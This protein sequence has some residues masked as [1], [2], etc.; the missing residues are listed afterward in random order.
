MNKKV[1]TREK[2]PERRVIQRASRIVHILRE[3][4]RIKMSLNYLRSSPDMDN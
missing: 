4:I 1:P 2:G 3:P